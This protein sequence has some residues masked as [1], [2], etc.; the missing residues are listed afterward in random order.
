L[1]EDDYES[2]PH[3]IDRDLQS[4]IHQPGFEAVKG[5]IIGRFQNGSKMEPEKLVEIIKSK[6]E[7][8]GIPVIANANF[9]HTTPQFTFPI[10]GRGK[11]V[12]K[13][14]K[15]KFTLLEH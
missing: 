14:G 11:L 15:V 8:T 5:L 4:V 12:V 2:S 13:N 6:Q 3:Y 7:L 1:L 10:G 9:G